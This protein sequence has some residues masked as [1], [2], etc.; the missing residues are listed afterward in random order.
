MITTTGNAAASIALRNAIFRVVPRTYVNAIYAKVREVAVGDAKTLDARRT[1]V[2]VRLEKIGVP[3]D[4]VFAKLDK[5]AVDDI[6]LEDL[7][8][9]IGLGTAIKNG[10]AQIDDLFPAVRPAPAAPEE[11]G[12]RISLGKKSKTVPHNPETG[13]VIEE[14]REPGSDG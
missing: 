12:K 6:G 9:L 11:D 8:V 10:E 14:K 1:E 3:R 5:R 7:E 13:E 4:R 2:L